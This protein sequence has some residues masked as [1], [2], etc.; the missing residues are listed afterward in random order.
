MQVT[1]TGPIERTAQFTRFFRKGM[2]NPACAEVLDTS[3]GRGTF[4]GELFI[5]VEGC[6]DYTACNYNPE[7]NSEPLGSCNFPDE[8]GRCDG[9]EAGPGIPEGAC[10]C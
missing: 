8:C 5:E 1:T 7:A 10:E 4:Q 6:M 9:E 3:A 2:A